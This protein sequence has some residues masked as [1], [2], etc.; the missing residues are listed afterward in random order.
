MLVEERT[1]TLVVEDMRAGTGR[2]F[3]PQICT[4]AMNNDWHTVTEN[5]QIQQSVTLTFFLPTGAEGLSL[6]L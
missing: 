6:A 3:Y 4:H 2:Q 1:D 5:R